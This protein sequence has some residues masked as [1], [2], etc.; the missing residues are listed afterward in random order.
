M[1]E[2]QSQVSPDSIAVV[3]SDE[4]VSY[5]ELNRRAEKVVGCLHEMGVRREDKIAIIAHK[6]VEM[7]VGMLGIMKSGAAFVPIDPEYPEDRQ[8]Y[9]IEDSGATIILTN[10]TKA[11]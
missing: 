8:Q 3:Y 1:I 9:M 5:S 10:D 6:S 11:R 4:H 2:T 7:M